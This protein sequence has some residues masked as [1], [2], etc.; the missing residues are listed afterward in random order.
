MESGASADVRSVARR[1]YFCVTLIAA[2]LALPLLAYLGWM[3][4][5]LKSPGSW[6]QR[7]GA[8]TTLAAAWVQVL[9]LRFQSNVTLTGFV[10]TIEKYPIQRYTQLYNVLLYAAGT[11]ALLGTAIWGYGDLL[12]GWLLCSGVSN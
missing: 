9:L 12:Y 2:A 6:F 4:P 11:V 1:L 5:A 10:K 3:K 7:S 8:L